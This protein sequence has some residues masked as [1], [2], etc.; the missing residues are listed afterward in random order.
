MAEAVKACC[1]EQQIII[2]TAAVADY[3]PA[4]PAEEKIKKKDN[5]STLELER[6]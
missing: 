1:Q 3:R 4:H 6:G 2:K 5:D